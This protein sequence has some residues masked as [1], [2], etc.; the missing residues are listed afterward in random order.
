[1][2]VNPVS[3]PGPTSAGQIETRARAVQAPAPAADRG[4]S[5]QRELASARPTEGD[6]P[7]A[8]FSNVTEVDDADRQKADQLRD[9]VKNENFTVRAYHDENSGRQ[10]I[11]VRDQT[12]GDV[13]SQYPSEELIRLYT[14]LRESLVDQRA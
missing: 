12:T 1:M 8:S 13:V 9:F 3:V 5:L 10:I 4:Q 7:Q 2:N 14:S 11:E 6:K